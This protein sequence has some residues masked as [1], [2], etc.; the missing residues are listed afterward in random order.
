MGEVCGYTETWAVPTNNPAALQVYLAMFGQYL[1]NIS[2]TTLYNISVEADSPAEYSERRDPL[3]RRGLQ[4]AE[5]IIVEDAATQLPF[6][7]PFPAPAPIDW[8]NDFDLA[9]LYPEYLVDNPLSPYESQNL[10][11]SIDCSLD[12]RE[13]L[14]FELDP[15]LHPTTLICISMD[16]LTETDRG[17]QACLT[18]TTQNAMRD[19][20]APFGMTPC[21]DRSYI[22]RPSLEI[23]PAPSPP[24]PNNWVIPPSPPVFG[25]EVEVVAVAGS[26]MGLYLMMACICCTVF[27][28]RSMRARHQSRWFTDRLW[29]VQGAVPYAAEESRREGEFYDHLTKGQLPARAHELVEDTAAS[30]AHPTFG[31]DLARA[32]FALPAGGAAPQPPAAASSSA[33]GFTFAS[34]VSDADRRSAAVPR[35]PHKNR[36]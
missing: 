11:N 8:R 25:Y 36:V 29:R 3:G 14:E 4:Q 32:L 16:F 31:T 26:G 7:I 27:G 5:S 17:A 24:P 2:N 19:L 9:T 35:T 20:L 34:L 33:S 13:E 23:I 28:G 6:T 22:C 30:A 18:M 10:Y 15:L 1:F 21:G 12:G